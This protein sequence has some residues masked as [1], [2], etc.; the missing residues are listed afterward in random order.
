MLAIFQMTRLFAE[1]IG[2]NLGQRILVVNR[3]GAAGTLA[4]SK[5]RGTGRGG[6]TTASAIQ[7]AIKT[8][9]AVS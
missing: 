9:R 7:H 4:A 3:P 6:E 5:H 2:L 1:A 8:N